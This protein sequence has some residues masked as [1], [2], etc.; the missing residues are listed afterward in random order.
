MNAV[1]GLLLALY[2]LSAGALLLVAYVWKELRNRRRNRIQRAIQSLQRDLP[3]EERRK[4][5]D[6]R[7]S[8]QSKILASVR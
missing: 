1:Q 3:F 4:G 2:L 7:T 6:R 5:E 8:D